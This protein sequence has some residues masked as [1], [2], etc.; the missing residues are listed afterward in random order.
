V[1]RLSK[2]KASDSDGDE[3]DRL[4]ML[5]MGAMTRKICSTWIDPA[6]SRAYY[7][8]LRRV[9]FKDGSP[10]GLYPACVVTENLLAEV[11]VIVPIAKFQELLEAWKKLHPEYVASVKKML[12]K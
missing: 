1:K 8:D 7:E 2:V 4:I 10:E 11:V 6:K 12:K 5:S 9:F 3:V